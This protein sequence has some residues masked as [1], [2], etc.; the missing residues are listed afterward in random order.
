MVAVVPRCDGTLVVSRDA[1]VIGEL[2]G[3]KPVKGIGVGDGIVGLAFV[4]DDLV[5]AGADGTLRRW[6][7]DEGRE[8]AKVFIDKGATG[9]TVG[10]DLVLSWPD[11]VSL[12]RREDLSERLRRTVADDRARA[13]GPS[14]RR[15]ARSGRRSL[16][17]GSPEFVGI[18][19]SVR[20]MST[21][22]CPSP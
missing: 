15:R 3:H 22:L 7:V 4:G 16:T 10:A 18:H 2:Q 9:M 5:S 12:H 11:H 19:S 1:C 14:T 21:G 17:R 6:S 13:C 8:L 20:M